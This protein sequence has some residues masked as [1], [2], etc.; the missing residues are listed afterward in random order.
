LRAFTL[1]ELL[2]VISIIG[3]LAAMLLPVVTRAQRAAKMGKAKLEVGQ[4]AAAIHD[5]ESAYNRF[6]ASSQAMAPG[7]DYTFGTTGTGA[8]AS[9]FKVPNNGT[10]YPILALDDSGTKVTYQTNNAEVMFI[11]L[12]L[13]SGPNVGHVKNPQR[14]KFLNATMV[15]EVNQPGVGPDGVYRDPWG[16][17]Y[18]I[19]V[20]F[21]N[22]DKAR[23][24]FYRLSAVSV[25]PNNAGHG[26]NGLI[27]NNNTTPGCYE[28]NGPVMVWSAGPD[29]MIDPTTPANQGANKD[30]ILSW[31]P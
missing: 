8:T 29:K 25:D 12:D 13:D 19:T 14:V 5:Y 30:N 9:G 6:P 22:D 4:I 28:L 26:L 18:I 27:Y 2:V 7:L 16:Q 1:V 10:P 3:I 31:K 15:S 17:P 23:D 21:N 20:D 11:L 24:A